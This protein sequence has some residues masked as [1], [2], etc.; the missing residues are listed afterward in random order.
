[1]QRNFKPMRKQIEVRKGTRLP[2]ETAAKLVIHWAFVEANSTRNTW[3]GAFT[4]S[5]STLRVEKLAPQTRR[6]LSN[7]F[8]SGFKE[9]LRQTLRLVPPKTY[10]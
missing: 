2:G 3:P 5:I 9:I 1:M 8:T 7:A 6:S 4:I 10:F